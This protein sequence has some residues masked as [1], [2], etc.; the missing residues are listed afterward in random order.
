[1]IGNN[2]FKTAIHKLNNAEVSLHPF[3]KIMS[4]P[5]LDKQVCA[6]KLKCIAL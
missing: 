4:F 5:N 2:C 3:V 6:L 1:M